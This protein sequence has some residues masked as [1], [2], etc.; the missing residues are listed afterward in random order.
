MIQN[1]G[2]RKVEIN[3]TDYRK[4]NPCVKNTRRKCLHVLHIK[5]QYPQYTKNP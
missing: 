2:A 1:S 3:K 5:S 4:I